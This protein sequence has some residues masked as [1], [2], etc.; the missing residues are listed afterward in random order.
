[1]PEADDVPEQPQVTTVAD[2]QW[3]GKIAP[4][5]EQ[6]PVLDIPSGVVACLFCGNTR[7]RRS[8]VRLSDM[9]EAL[10]LRFPLRC[11]RCNQRQYGSYLTASI[12]TGTRA[13]GPHLSKGQDTWKSW[14]E[15]E[16]GSKLHRP[17][18]TAIGSRAT[19]LRMPVNSGQPSATGKLP[20]WRDEDR[21][22]W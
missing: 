1:M 6:S 14:T 8:R 21:P 22:I 9:L 20:A 16:T 3:K 17:M 18:S 2:K 7:F 19:K 15:R 10:L 4:Y 12:A 11:M 5:A 13:H